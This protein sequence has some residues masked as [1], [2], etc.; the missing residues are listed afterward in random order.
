MRTCLVLGLGG[1]FAGATGPLL[2]AYIPPLVE[3]ALGDNRFGIGLVMAIDNVLL[4]LLVPLTGIASD[5][6]RARGG[7]RVPL[8]LAGYAA[9][10]MSMAIFPVAATAGLAGL[11]AAMV[12]LY[13]GI[14]AQRTPF[15]ALIADAVPSRL[16]SIATGLVTFQMCA[17]AVLMLMLGRLL[18]MATAF[19]LAAVLVAATALVFAWWFHSPRM[20]GRAEQPRMGGYADAQEG[21]PEDPTVRALVMSVTSALRGD[22][23][24]LRAIFAATFLLQLTFQSFST[25]YALHAMER[26]GISAEEAG[27]GF[28]AWALGGVAGALPAGVI[29][30]RLGRRNAMILGF[31]LQTAALATLTLVTRPLPV[32][33]LLGLASASWTLPMVNAYPLFVEPI[34]PHRRGVLAALFLLAMALGGI[35]GDPLNGAVFELAGGYRPLFVL[36]AGYTSLALVA[37]VM[38]RRGTGEADEEIRVQ[39]SGRDVGSETHD[40]VPVT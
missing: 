11:I 34:P 26:F 13:T 27:L 21:P 6:T 9:T 36:M 29:G 30:V 37:V 39:G 5:R 32:A 8:V 15:Q 24:G 23:P 16:R 38:V 35:V 33:L 40:G 3:G 20:R 25:W 28:I 31:G 1:L 19:R 17:G 12:L 7:S 2:S 10:A 18:G 4:L 14:N 22:L